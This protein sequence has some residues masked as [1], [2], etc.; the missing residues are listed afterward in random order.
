MSPAFAATTNLLDSTEFLVGTVS[1]IAALLGGAVVIWYL[2]RWRKQ[3]QRGAAESTE[4]LTHFR[5]LFENGEITETEYK[6]I[7]GK[8]STQM[9]KEVGLPVPIPVVEPSPD[10]PESVP[11]AKP[12]DPTP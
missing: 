8:V 4:S 5:E 3:Q 9:R 11:P 1:L 10:P 12:P 6:R 7:R 2:D